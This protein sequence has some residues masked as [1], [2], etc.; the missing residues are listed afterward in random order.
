MERKVVEQCPENC[1]GDPSCHADHH[2]HDLSYCS[3]GGRRGKQAPPRTQGRGRCLLSEALKAPAA[4]LRGPAAP[5]AAWG[6]PCSGRLPARRPP[7]DSRPHPGGRE[8][9][10]C[11]LPAFSDQTGLP[12]SST[13]VSRLCPGS[14]PLLVALRW[15]WV[16]TVQQVSRRALRRPSLLRPPPSG[17]HPWCR[18]RGGAGT[19]GAR[20]L[21]PLLPRGG[22][23]CNRCIS[24]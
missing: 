5:A 20:S 9:R 11:P 12:L 6:A 16:C 18:A 23:D 13:R 2:G 8:G 21:R 15:V 1:P 17:R 24:L 22:Q 19:R 4:A 10:L 7:A 14:A 3:M